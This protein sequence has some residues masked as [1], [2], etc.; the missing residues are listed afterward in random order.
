[1]NANTKVLERLKKVA[2]RSQNLY[3]HAAGIFDRRGNLICVAHNNGK[4]HAE[5]RCAARMLAVP[6]F[7]E[8]KAAYMI[9]VRISKRGHSFS[10]SA[11]CVGCQKI[12][13]KL[14]LMVFHS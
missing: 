12:L 8:K 5:M 2:A 6:K 11:P 4:S 9:V 10:P 7:R 3:K 1:M 13:S 14:D